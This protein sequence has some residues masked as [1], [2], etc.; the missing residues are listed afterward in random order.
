[1]PDHERADIIS[2]LSGDLAET[3]AD[4]DLAL[5][6][7]RIH[8]LEQGIREALTAVDSVLDITPVPGRI[9]AKLL[10]PPTPEDNQ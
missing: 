2:Y 1:M 5:A 7:S 9:L 6:L 8:Q 10:E 3:T 4:L